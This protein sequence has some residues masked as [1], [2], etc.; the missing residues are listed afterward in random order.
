[1]ETLDILLAA[2]DA[3]SQVRALLIDT[4]VKGYLITAIVN[5]EK[6]TETKGNV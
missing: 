5:Y 4:L 6:Q 3:D 2:I 1:M